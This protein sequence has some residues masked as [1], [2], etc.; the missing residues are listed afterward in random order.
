M[1]FL[2]ANDVRIVRLCGLNWNRK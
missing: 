2:A 1:G